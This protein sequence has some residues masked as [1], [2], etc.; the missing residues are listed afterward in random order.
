M[1]NNKKVSGMFGFYLKKIYISNSISKPNFHLVFRSHGLL[2][3]IWQTARWKDVVVGD[4]VKI[5]AGELFPAD[6]VLLS[7]RYFIQFALSI[8]RNKILFLLKYQ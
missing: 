8:H 4:I 2:E 1:L 6:L 3:P 7:S 5:V